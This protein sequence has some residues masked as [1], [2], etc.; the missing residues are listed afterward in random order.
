MSDLIAF[1]PARADSKRLKNKNLLPVGGVPLIVR[2]VDYALS[3]TKHVVVST[4]SEVIAQ[5]VGNNAQIVSRPR[6]LFQDDA[7]VDDVVTNFLTDIAAEGISSDVLVIQPTTIM[8]PYPVGQIDMMRSSA[9]SIA[10]AAPTHGIWTGKKSHVG[11]RIN[12]QNHD[13]TRGPWQEM[14]IRFYPAGS[15]DGRPETIHKCSINIE[16]VDIDTPIDLIAADR[17]LSQ[18]HIVF[19]FAYG[20]AIGSGHLNRSITLANH[21]Q[22]HY[23]SLTNISGDDPVPD[24]MRGGWDTEAQGSEFALDYDVIINDV[25]NTTTAEMAMLRQFGPVIAVEDNGPGA[26]L[27][28]HVVN[29][30]YPGSPEQ[31]SGSE[32]AILRPE[33]LLSENK[34][35]KDREM[36]SKKGKVMEV[37][38]SQLASR[39]LPGTA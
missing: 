16:Y 9:K 7:S 18:L 1:I 33:F 20:T 21:L 36:A 13:N 4:D 11:S 31:F 26:D 23:V 35:I 15:T 38:T 27:A 2:A 10:L 24:E 22:H 8:S 39:V 19:R 6:H 37:A 12:S 34:P 14:G 30:L 17:L 5:L 32:W 29:A 25:L 28:S 3:F